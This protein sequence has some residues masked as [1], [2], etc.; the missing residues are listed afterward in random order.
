MSEAEVKVW[1]KERKALITKQVNAF[2][3]QINRYMRRIAEE[4]GFDP[5]KFTTYSARHTFTNEALK[6]MKDYMVAK[7]L[8]Q[9]GTKTLNKHYANRVDQA[10]KEDVQKD[11][12]KY[13]KIS[14]T[15]EKPIAKAS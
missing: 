6:F 4:L 12:S 3:K 1:E 8:G 9:T 7:L 11:L 14:K 5:K 15:Q 2:T 13:V 10:A